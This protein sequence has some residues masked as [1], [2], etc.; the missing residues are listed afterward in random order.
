MLVGFGRMVMSRGEGVV[1]PF[2]GEFDRISAVEAR[3]ADL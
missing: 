1:T 3:D 2:E